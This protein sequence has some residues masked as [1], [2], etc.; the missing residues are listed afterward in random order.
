MNNF[1]PVPAL[2]S[3]DGPRRM[4]LCIRYPPQSRQEELRNTSELKQF[5]HMLPQSKMWRGPV[6]EICVQLLHGMELRGNKVLGPGIVLSLGNSGSD[7][8][9]NKRGALSRSTLRNRPAGAEARPLCRLVRHRFKQV[10][11]KVVLAKEC[12]KKIA[13]NCLRS[14]RWVAGD[15]FVSPKIPPISTRTSFS[16][17]L[18]KAI[19]LIR[20]HAPIHLADGRVRIRARL[21]ARRK[22]RKE[23]GFSRCGC[24]KKREREA[25]PEKL[26]SG[27]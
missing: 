24:N 14:A 13:H 3:R 12:Q 10:A 18:F 1:I 11:E 27:L 22:P 23:G 6:R 4:R 26:T 25:L 7:S 2:A 15:G 8:T 17:S 19:A 5:V 20:T 9:H 16:A 21:Q